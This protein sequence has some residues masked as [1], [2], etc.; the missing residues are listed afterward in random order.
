MSLYCGHCGS[1][2]HFTLDC[3]KKHLTFVPPPEKEP[4]FEL[5]PRWPGAPKICTFANLPAFETAT[6]MLNYNG[7]FGTKID[8]KWKC[9]V[10]KGWHYLAT[11]RSP[12][13]DSSGH[14]RRSGPIPGY[15]KYF[16]RASSVQISRMGDLQ[17][18]KTEPKKK[19]ELPRKEKV[20]SKEGNLL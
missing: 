4:V 14:S 2:S 9:K 20:K 13:G 16:R 1:Q 15:V 11:P 7:L 6:A 5:K 12:S 17:I 18:S 19:V 3:A 10:C 8:K